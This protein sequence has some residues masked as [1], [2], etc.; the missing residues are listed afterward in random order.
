MI[1]LNNKE[2]HLSPISRETEFK[3][4]VGSMQHD[5]VSLW[6]IIV[7]GRNHL[8]LSDEELI[9]FVR[10]AVSTLIRAGGRPSVSAN[11]GRGLMKAVTRYGTTPEDI[12]EA[13]ITEWAVFGYATP[14]PPGG[15]W[16]DSPKAETKLPNAS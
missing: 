1:D 9:S 3:E 11:T 8:G 14:I 4:L 10:D 13:L 15:L 16:F 5:L 12:A 2:E 6:E 7:R